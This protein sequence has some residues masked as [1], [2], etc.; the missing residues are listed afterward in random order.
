MRK[1]PIVLS[2]AAVL[3]TAVGCGGS[4]SDSGGSSDSEGLIPVNFALANERSIQYHP[5][6][7]ARDAG[8]FEEEG[9]DVD[10]S[11][12]SGGGAAV[13]QL[14]AGNAD[15]LGVGAASAISAIDSG[16]DLV[17]S[18][19]YFYE[20][21]FT[22]VTPADSGIESLEDL[23]GQTVGIT[24]PGGGEVPLVR[25][26]FASA[27]MVDGEDY[28]MLAVGEGGQLTY[29][30]LDKGQVQAYVSSVY[31]VASIEAAGMELNRILPEEFVY[32]PSIG[33]VTTRETLEDNRD[34]VVKFNRA[35]AKAT[36]FSQQNPDAARAIARDQQPELFD[37]PALADA[38]WDT[39]Q[40]LLTPPDSVDS[41]VLGAHYYDGWEL[42]I[43]SS[44]EGTAEEGALQTDID[45]RSV[46]DES[47]LEEVN[48]FD[49]DAV[50]K[51]ADEYP[52]D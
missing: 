17:W 44:S 36:V 1:I 6:Y 4:D 13:Q 45:V 26:V 7:V 37:D 10:M 12:Y 33:N 51:T 30:A 46:A 21:I 47:L 19:S 42:Y 5:Y 32:T 52:V 29:D 35:I 24:D 25:S 34:L 50:R 20:N 23:R 27:G 14:V 22:M 3:A 2:I 39:T 9:L 11:I 48:D 43:E 31:D 41:D 49:Q 18:Y 8:F 28:Q 40:R 15:I 38:M 16:Q